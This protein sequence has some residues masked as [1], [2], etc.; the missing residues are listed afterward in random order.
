MYG[1]YSQYIIRSHK[2]QLFTEK[3]TKI[4]LSL[5]DDK[6]YLLTKEQ[7]ETLGREL[8]DTLAWGHYSIVKHL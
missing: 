1:K 8:T 3:V 4:S 6:R 7:A 5:H 2:H